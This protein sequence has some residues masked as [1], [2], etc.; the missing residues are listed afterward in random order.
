[1]VSEGRYSGPRGRG[2]WNTRVERS[3]MEGLRCDRYRL[4]EM[5]LKVSSDRMEY[6]HDGAREMAD[7]IL[8][9]RSNLEAGGTITSAS[10]T[11]SRSRQP[12]GQRGHRA[13]LGTHTPSAILY[14]VNNPTTVIKRLVSAPLTHGRTGGRPRRP[15]GPPTGWSTGS[16]AHGI[17]AKSSADSLVHRYLGTKHR[18]IA[19]FWNYNTRRSRSQV[20]VIIRYCGSPALSYRIEKSTI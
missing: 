3:C 7:A 15:S 1:M 20:A 13:S 8:M 11:W 14:Q 19:L 4:M 16:R 9:S 10:P 5:C 12:Q 17:Q 2:D 18:W 6:D